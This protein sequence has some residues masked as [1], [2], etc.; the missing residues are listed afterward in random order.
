[1]IR[2]HS[3]EQLVSCDSVKVAHLTSRYH[4]L[5]GRDDEDLGQSV[6]DDEEQRLETGEGV[7]NVDQSSDKDEQTEDERAQV[8]KGH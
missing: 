6:E 4:A 3:L 5:L 8:I 7:A 1:M 2:S